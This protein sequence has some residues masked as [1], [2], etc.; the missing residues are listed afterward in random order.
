MDRLWTVRWVWMRG[1]QSVEAI[2]HPFWVRDDGKE[3]GRSWLIPK[4]KKRKG[5]F[6][7]L[8]GALQDTRGKRGVVVFN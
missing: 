7:D 2:P 6:G 4:V 1:S 3:G 8:G 5:D